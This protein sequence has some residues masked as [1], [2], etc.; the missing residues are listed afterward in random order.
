MTFFFVVNELVTSTT[1]NMTVFFDTIQYAPQPIS[2]GEKPKSL[3]P[4]AEN[5]RGFVWFCGLVIDEQRDEP[6]A[7]VASGAWFFGGLTT[8]FCFRLLLIF[9]ISPVN[10]LLANMF[11]KM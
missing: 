11:F 10:P 3:V 7:D 1:T 5:D 8:W 4:T 6:S 9:P 2:Q